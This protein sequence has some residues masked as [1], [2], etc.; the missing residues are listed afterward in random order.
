MAKITITL[1]DNP[2]METVKVVSNPPFAELAELSKAGDLT[3]A[4]GFAVSALLHLR[5]CGDHRQKKRSRNKI[6]IP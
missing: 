6:F 3:Y 2:N 1:E 4:Q 5:Q